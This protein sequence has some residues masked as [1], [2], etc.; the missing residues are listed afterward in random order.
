MQNNTTAI[1]VF[2]SGVGG[3]SVLKSIA[4]TLPKQPLIYMADSAYAPYGERSDTFIEQR[5]LALAQWLLGKQVSA[6]VV[7]CNTATSVAVNAL[8]ATVSIPVVAIEPPIKPACQLSTAK[9]IG[10][11][12]TTRTVNSNN[13]AQLIKHYGEGC[14]VFLQACPGLVAQIE[15]G[16]FDS[17]Q[18]RALLHQYIDPLVAK[19]IDY[20]VLGCT[21]YPFLWN[22]IAAVA[23]AGV[24]LLEPAQA[25]AR[26]LKRRLINVDDPAGSHEK[27]SI[28]F[29]S[30]GDIVLANKVM[31]Q[32]W[33]QPM[34]VR[35]FIC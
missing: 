27:A 24:T 33:G 3:L 16:Q 25:V 5:A 28:A 2:D 17:A 14:D 10:V 11:L 35:P 34:T 23:G 31:S 8:R 6:I 20:L 9:K 18:T 13:V 1:G 21:H 32:L 7:A 12:A 30:N 19:G 22:Q 26:E 4:Q 29:Y 15:A